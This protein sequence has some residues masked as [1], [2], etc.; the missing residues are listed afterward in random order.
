M[1]HRI[2]LL[3]GINMSRIFRL[4]SAS[5][6][7]L[8]IGLT[9]ISTA[10]AASTARVVA[11]VN[12]DAITSIDLDERM[13]IAISSS[14]LPDTAEVKAR[15]REQILQAL[16]DER[17]AMQEGERLGITLAAEELDQAKRGVEK[18]NNVQEGKLE[19]FLK[20]Q[21]VSANAVM[22]QIRAQIMWSKIVARK[23][24]PR[25]T[26]STR[27]IQE[28]NE[29]ISSASG[30]MEVN[31]GEIVLPVP[32][33]SLEEDALKLAEK[34]AD[35]IRNGKSFAAIA[36]QFSRSPS[37]EQGGN[38]GWIGLSQL[39]PPVAKTV[40]QL[41]RGSISEPLRL[42]DGYYLFAL[43][44]KRALIPVEQGDTEVAVKQL[45]LPFA[46]ESSKDT[47]EKLVEK[48]NDLREKISSCAQFDDIAINAGSNVSPELLRVQLNKF[49]DSL[50]AVVA[51]TGVGQVSPVVKSRS[52]LHLIMVCERIEATPSLARKEQILNS[53]R[54]EKLSAQARRYRRQL[55]QEALIEI[56]AHDQNL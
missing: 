37:A 32:E 27:E 30:L 3:E 52:G 47:Q 23:I 40:G 35:E 12:D 36:K 45:F 38:V 54:N 21:G 55:R 31:I 43:Y 49:N 1:H 4:F 50:Q 20:T 56:R 8:T 22:E 41:S 14:K 10:K 9:V 15:L 39:S 51:E 2:L 42:N 17:L 6:L 46:P 13:Q 25:V 26:V 11:T 7:S 48:A 29:K 24:R 53:L 18:H 16:I 33:P 28:A 44:D 34:L 5:L 19:E